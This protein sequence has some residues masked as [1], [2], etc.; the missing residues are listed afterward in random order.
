MS[1]DFIGA[2]LESEF[3]K[4]PPS[5]L[6]LGNKR[7]YQHQIK[8]APSG[9]EIYL[10]LPESYEVPIDDLRW[11][12]KNDINI[13]KVN[14][15][16]SLGA[17]LVTALNLSGCSLEADLHILFGDT[18]INSLPSGKDIVGVSMVEGS[19]NWAI[20]SVDRAP[21]FIQTADH[22]EDS[23]NKIV[24]GYFKF[25]K[26]R[27]LIRALCQHNW[28]FLLGLN[29]YHDYIGLVAV[30][31]TEWLDFGH[32]N[33]YYHSKSKFTTQRSFN[34][35]KITSDWVRKESS[36][37]L[38]I[39]AEA[40]WFQNLPNNLK[41]FTPQFLGIEKHDG[42]VS[43]KLEYLHNTAL[44]ELFVFAEI[45]LFVWEKILRRC[46]DFILKCKST[47]PPKDEPIANDANDLFENKTTIR[48]KSFCENSNFDIS[49]KWVYNDELKASLEDILN[50]SKKHLCHTDGL[51]N[52]MHGDFCFS[53][54]LYDFRA[55]RLKVIDPRGLIN[56]EAISIYG[57]SLYD[58]A[59]LSHSI[60]GM[61]DWIISGYFNLT[62]ENH[63]IKFEVSGL[64][65]HSEVQ[66][67]Y[68]SLV[69]SSF[70]ITPLNL[71][72]MQIQL[73]LSMLPL[74]SDSP[75][76]QKAFL[77]NTF[78]LYAIMKSLEK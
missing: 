48:L 10:T 73:F 19:Y 61:Y 57:S 29:S 46:I 71:Y 41:G 69:C 68:I 25:S 16:L 43:Y 75:L 5:F 42:V 35:L 22:L 70:N 63:E 17:S 28:D 20:V 38:K 72:A 53:N 58:I 33:N 52:V 2:E 37:N 8:L 67:K 39:F 54:I 66:K 49:E 11:L 50:A 6:P 26:P 14:N 32:V 40:Q 77:A 27:D 44:N 12:K 18:L 76:R 55:N 31:I 34:D 23:S 3:G 65:K 4:I 51:I 1:G 9:H 15:T 56:K 45:P 36:E 24:N 62:M 30:E 74:H 13:V 64:D 7:L 59:K 21:W 47:I 78:R 60:L